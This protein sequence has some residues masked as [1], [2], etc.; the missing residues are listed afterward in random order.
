MEKRVVEPRRLLWNA[1]KQRWCLKGYRLRSALF[2]AK[3]TWTKLQPAN[4]LKPQRKQLALAFRSMYGN[5]KQ[6][7]LC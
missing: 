2:A 7:D 1:K 3:D 6:P 4:F 5:I